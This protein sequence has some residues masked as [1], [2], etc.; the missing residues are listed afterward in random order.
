M[1]AEAGAEAMRSMPEA[2]PVSV[3]LARKVRDRSDFELDFPLDFFVAANHDP[4]ASFQ[5]LHKVS[6][7][8]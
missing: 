8:L 1:L 7:I 5:L 4:A 2:T 6:F 3:P